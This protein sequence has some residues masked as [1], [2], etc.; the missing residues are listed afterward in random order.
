MNELRISK[1]LALP[2]DTVT[3]TTIVYGGK[4]MGKTNFGSV[5][6]EE[7]SAANLRYSVI[8]PLGVWWGL[9]YAAD[10][11]APGIEVLMLGGVHGDI[12]IE[13]T[14]GAVIADLVADENVN[15]VID[16]SRKPD[17][18]M[19]SQG[20]KIRFVTDYCI[21]LFERQGE[22]RRPLLQI[23]DEAARF[24]PQL[25]PSGAV[26]VAKC[27]GA[28]ERMQ[29][30]GRNVGIG[31][32]LMTQRS[33]RMNKSVSEL[34]D[35][36]ISFR[37]VGPRSVA[38]VM[39]WLG[40][41]LPKDQ[42]KETIDTIRKL[43]VGAALVVSPG[44]LDFEG[45]A[46]IRFRRTFD[47]S[48][49][50]KPGEDAKTPTGK[51]AKPDLAK[52][53]ERMVETIEK[54]KANDPKELKKRIIELEKQIAEGDNGRSQEEDLATIR[55][56]R[57]QVQAQCFT[58]EKLE[59][60]TGMLE[61]ILGEFSEISIRL[62]DLASDFKVSDVRERLAQ[63]DAREEHRNGGP[64][65]L[66]VVTPPPVPK[67]L[68]VVATTSSVSTLPAAQQ[69]I[70]DTLALFETLGNPRPSLQH[71][72]AVMG[73]WHNAGP[74]RGAFAHLRNAG[75]IDE[76]GQC[77]ALTVSGRKLADSS[78][79]T[80]RNV[81]E[82]H[83]MWLGRHSGAA[84]NILAVL[85]DQHPRA[86]TLEAL[87]ERIGKNINAGP[88]RGAINKLVATSLAYQQGGTVVATDL[89]FPQLTGAK[90]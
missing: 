38:A 81:S 88:I 11:K 71:I 42:I 29:E 59:E 40:E 25:I 75:L 48:Q 65:K 52:Y 78:S 80:L 14:G 43:P 19:W 63:M 84:R 22:K 56:L 7:L 58:I 8:D 57:E 16:I 61:H 17:G 12:P 90:L 66:E 85:I 76:D 83:S 45:I 33:A 86:I 21:R 27:V 13:P 4:G 23:I 36:M 24:V 51:A 50:P 37:I 1:D 9:Q 18:T 6:A 10:G 67:P 32:L 68:P 46:Q 15:V 72:G 47:S 70:L 73:K 3:S 31:M 44:W 28:I 35:C 26:D 5:L 82:V 2:L 54:A 20:D 55:E 39:D 87:G 77:A 41:H 69:R 62:A 30:E 74:I 49:T 60:R 89:L 79:M 64:P 53:Q 34:A